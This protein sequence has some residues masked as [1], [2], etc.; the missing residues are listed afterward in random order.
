[1]KKM[2]IKLTL[3]VNCVSNLSLIGYFYT[4]SEYNFFFVGFNCM[5]CA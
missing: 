5:D 2:L 1:M 3:L 4:Y